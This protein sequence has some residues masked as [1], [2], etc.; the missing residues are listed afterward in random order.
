M[1]EK[2]T[3]TEAETA[4]KLRLSRPTL[5][6]IRQQ[7]KIAYLRIGSKIFYTQKNID[8]FLEASEVSPK[9]RLIKKI[10]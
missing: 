3:Y 2:L 5:I 9:R 6:K 7:G 1:D 8:E 10:S 4:D